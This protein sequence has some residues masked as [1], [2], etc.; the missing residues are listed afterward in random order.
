MAAYYNEFD[1]FAA[2][3]LRELIAAGLIPAGD[4]DER[5]IADV[6]AK[7]VESY[8]Q[9]HWFAGIGG[10]ALALRLAGWGDDRPVWT[11]SCPCQ[12]FSVAGS[13]KAEADERHLWPE[14]RRLIADASPSVCFGEQVASP[15]G[16]RW[17]SGVRA[18]LEDLGYGVGAADLCAAGVRAPHIRQRLWWVADSGRSERRWRAQPGGEHGGALHAS[19]RCGTD[20]LA[21]SEH[22]E[23]RHGV[24]RS[25]GQAGERRHRFADDRPDVGLADDDGYGRGEVRGGDSGQECAKPERG[26]ESRRLGYAERAERRP[27]IEHDELSAG[28]QQAT[29]GPRGAGDAVPGFWGAFRIIH[30]R[31]G[32][33]RRVPIESGFLM[34]AD[35]FWYRMADV[36]AEFAKEALE[37]VIIYGRNHKASPE[38]TVPVV[39]VAVGAEAIQRAAGGSW[40][41]LA[42]EVLFPLMWNELSARHGAP[43]QRGGTQAGAESRRRMLRDLREHIAPLCSSLRRESKEQ[44]SSQPADALRSLS[45]LLARMCEAC[46]SLSRGQDAAAFPLAGVKVQGR[47]GLL[48]GAGNAIFAITEA[49]RAMLKDI[50]AAERQPA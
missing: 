11:G 22:P 12:P 32:K 33:A 47:V 2:A 21:D 19:D 26:S 27:H 5:S 25:E 42:E 37:E 8:T 41:V 40:G 4:V 46:W 20:R 17:L 13:G 1:P 30:C 34:L 39:Q 44:R 31:D 9:A 50:R 10:W 15:A 24:S 7:D 23:S 16:R 45:Q 49:G 36:Y 48:R 28:W 29:G 6:E 14:F 43:N 3:W 18:D 35:G 38:E